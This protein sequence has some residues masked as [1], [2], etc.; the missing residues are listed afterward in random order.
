MADEALVKA[1]NICEGI[2]STLLILQHRL[3]SKLAQPPIQI[4]KEYSEL[5]NIECYARQLIRYL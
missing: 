1:V 3:E 4:V 2:E 5:P